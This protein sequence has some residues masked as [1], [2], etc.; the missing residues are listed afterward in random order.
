LKITRVSTAIVQANFDWTIIRVETDEGLVGWGEAFFAPGLTA[1]VK[2]LGEFISGRDPREIEPIRRDMLDASSAAGVSGQVYHAITGIDAALWDILGQH[3][4]APL[5]QLW[6][7]KFRDRVSIYCDCHGGD[8]LESLD[9][10]LQARHLD[11]DKSRSRW[12]AQSGTATVD[13]LPEY[14]PEAYVKKAQ[15]QIEKGFTFL[16][17]DVDVPNPYSTDPYNRH[18]GVSEVTYLAQLMIQVREAVGPDVELC[19]D[20]HWKFSP[21]AS[22]QLAQALQP[23]RLAWLEDPVPPHNL[24]ALKYV[25]DHSPV[26]I[27][28]GE[29]LYGSHEFGPLL[30]RQAVAIVAP[31][32]QKVGGL[33]EGRRICQMAD[34]YFLSVAPHNIASPIGT[35]A[36]VHVA[37]SIPN[38]L[39]LEWHASDVP[40][41]ADMIQEGELIHQGFIAVPSRPGLG[42][43]PN[44][45]TMRRYAKPGEPFFQ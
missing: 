41:W 13:V 4:E 24:D 39:A 21:E 27:L 5:W 22:V 25:R 9:S 7:G 18:L 36:S 20:C 35:M 17:F 26:P 28:S 43:T 42:V 14:T 3:L 31:D 1:T 45:E 2:E 32:F 8:A 12:N 34:Q 37:A 40:F 6:G 44:E 16:K 30:A 10:L 15:Q 38:F 11:W 29:N 33:S 23:A 19:A